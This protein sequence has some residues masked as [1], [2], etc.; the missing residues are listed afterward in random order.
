MS[1]R[2]SPALFS[3]VSGSTTPPSS[4]AVMSMPR[5]TRTSSSEDLD[6][7]GGTC[8][9]SDGKVSYVFDDAKLISNLTR[10]TVVCER[11]W[12]ADRPPSRTR[13]LLGRRVLAPGEGLLLHP[14][15]SIHTVAIR[16]SIDVVFVDREFRVVKVVERLRPWR[17]AGASG[18]RSALELPAGEVEARGVSVGD[19]LAAHDR[20]FA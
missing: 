1:D 12:K 15:P 3:L 13:G 4:V 2:T 8:D 6:V 19:Q 20:R 9:R 11:A 7:R 18:A 14:A 17:V 10:G 16:F 5:G